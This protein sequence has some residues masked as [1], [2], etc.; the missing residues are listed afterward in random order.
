MSEA[1]SRWKENAVA[2]IGSGLVAALV[3]NPLDVVKV[4][5]IE[6]IYTCAKCV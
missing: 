5:D 1:N 2:A 6:R 4:R 3:T